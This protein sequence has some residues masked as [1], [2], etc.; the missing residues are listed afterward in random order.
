[1]NGG[2]GDDALLF[3]GLSDNSGAL[4]YW[5]N[6]LSS[7]SDDGNTV[8]HVHDV[9]GGGTDVSAITLPGVTTDIA[10]LV[11]DGIAGFSAA[12]DWHTLL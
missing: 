10:T 4:S 9:H 6:W 7:T 2:G 3:L 12:H 8:I 1:M 11:N 5:A